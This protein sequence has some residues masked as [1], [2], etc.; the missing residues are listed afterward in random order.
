MLVGTEII[1][2]R[3]AGTTQMVLVSHAHVRLKLLL[4]HLPELTCKRKGDM[5][6]QA[7]SPSRHACCDGVC[8]IDLHTHTLVAT[9]LIHAEHI[10]RLGCSQCVA[11]SESRHTC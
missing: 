5:P 3:A 8:M 1:L 10:W 4:I 9:C 2:Q 11:W 6:T 7:N